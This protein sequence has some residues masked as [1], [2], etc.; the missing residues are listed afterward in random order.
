VLKVR[1][2]HLLIA[3]LGCV[4]IAGLAVYNATGQAPT[5]PAAS[6]QTGAPRIAVVDIGYIFKMHAGF[7]AR[8]ADLEAEMKQAS[9][10]LKA[11]QE[12][13]RKMAQ[14]LQKMQ[15]G[16]EQYKRQEEEIAR[17]NSDLQVRFSLQDKEFARKEA[18]I[19]HTVYKEVEQEVQYL[20]TQSGLDAVLRFNGDEVD[21]AQP[22]QVMRNVNK[23]VVWFNGELDITP[24]ILQRLNTRYGAQTA[25]PTVPGQRSTPRHG[26]P[27][28][29]YNR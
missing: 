17:R 8:K 25:N 6:P 23:L 29:S 11:E 18:N 27:S 19:Y 21:P 26:V 3:I 16:T 2:T 4:L 15:P 9:E 20:A 7:K 14:E 1:K 22:A 28:P 10:R 24:H 5:R 13:L 12:A